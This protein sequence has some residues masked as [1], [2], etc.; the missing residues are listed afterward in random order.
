[1]VNSIVVELAVSSTVSRSFLPVKLPFTIMIT[2]APNAP[3]APAS[4]G[5]AAPV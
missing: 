5:V 2:K 3:K 1:M 4:V